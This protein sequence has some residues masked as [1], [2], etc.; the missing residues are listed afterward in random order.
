MPKTTC[1]IL[2][3]SAGS[4]QDLDDVTARLARLPNTEIRLTT[5][6]GSAARFAATAIK[7]GRQTIMRSSTEGYR[8]EEGPHIR[9]SALCATCHTLITTALGSGGKVV[10]ALPE[11]MPYPEWLHSDYKNKQSCQECHMPKINEPVQIS[12]VLGEIREGAR[13][14]SFVGG[15]FFMLNMLNRYREELSVAALPAE[16]AGSVQATMEFLQTQSA[17]VAIENVAAESGRIRADVVVRNK[18]GHKLPTAYPSR[19]VWVHFTVR[20]GNGRIFQGDVA[21]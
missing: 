15:N 12:R 9:E 21:R 8:P 17:T 10:G 20:D 2:N 4:I 11:Q 6:R 18:S 7:K 3:P 16:L 5:K 19:R 1:V 13:L 14:H